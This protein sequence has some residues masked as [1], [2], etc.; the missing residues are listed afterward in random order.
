MTERRDIE[1][2]SHEHQMVPYNTL[3]RSMHT[4]YS[5]RTDRLCCMYYYHT[6]TDC[7]SVLLELAG[8]CILSLH[9]LGNRLDDVLNHEYKYKQKHKC[10]TLLTFGPSRLLE[11]HQSYWH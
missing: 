7:S 11:K 6:C 5:T 4:E 10:S 3:S 8:K 1:C 2:D 9:I